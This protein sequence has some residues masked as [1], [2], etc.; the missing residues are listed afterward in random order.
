M[1]V[2]STEQRLHVLA[3]LVD[4]NSERAIERMTGVERKTIRR[5][6]LRLGN[7]AQSLH[8]TIA[9][10]LSVSCIENDEIWSYV[11][12]KQAR[13]TDAENA[14][15]LGEAYTF[16]ALAMPSR[17][18]VTWKVGKRD[19]ATADAFITDL[20]ARLVTMPAMTSDGFP[21]YPAPIAKNFPGVDYAQV[22]K[23]YSR[24]SRKDDDHRY[25]PPRD[26]FITR[27]AIFG[28]PDVER[29]T[30]AHIERNNGTMRHHI[31]RMRRLCYAFSKSPAHHNAA[32]ALAYCHYNL[33]WIPRTTR[34]TPA[35]AANATDHVWEL[36]ELL[37]ALLSVPETKTPIAG[38]L[39]PRTPVGPARELPAGRGFLRLVGGSGGPSAPSPAPTSPPAVAAPIEPA[40]EPTGQLDLLNWTPRVRPLPPKGTQL[41]LFGEPES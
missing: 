32:V 29:A 31:G 36:G 9:R 11:G 27:K 39:A 16:V 26:P 34:V 38:P 13:V 33:C 21:A 1:S 37:D 28:A 14:A 4:G 23:D 22:I 25:E 41:N 12:K 35:L 18:V 19:D 30:T 7:A 17:F 40:A 3:G 2:L 8:N 5:L 20:R 10:D 24:K 6:A 15:G